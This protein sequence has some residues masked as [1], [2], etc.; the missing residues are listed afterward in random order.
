MITRHEANTYYPQ[1]LFR[2][3]DISKEVNVAAS[4]DYFD[5]P[6]EAY[7]ARK[8][9]PQYRLG[10]AGEVIAQILESGS[11]EQGWVHRAEALHV[12]SV[13][14]L[15]ELAPKDLVDLLAPAVGRIID[16]RSEY[17]DLH[18]YSGLL[19]RTVSLA[20]SKLDRY[21]VAFDVM[22]R[23]H[24]QLATSRR[25]HSAIYIAEAWQQIYLQECGQL[26]RNVEAALLEQDRELTRLNLFGRLPNR[27]LDRHSELRPLRIVARAAAESGRLATAYI[28]FVKARE[29]LPAA[30]DP[31][32][33][34]LAV[35]SWY[36]TSAIMYM[37]A[38]LLAGLIELCAHADPSRYLLPVPD[39]WASIIESNGH[40]DPALTVANQMDLARNGL[41]WAFLHSGEH[42]YVR[43]T[44]MGIRRGVPDYLRQPVGSKLDTVRCADEIARNK[45]NAGILDNLAHSDTYRLLAER[46]GRGPHGYEAWL[47]HRHG[48][49][50]TV[51]DVNDAKPAELRTVGSPTLRY[52]RATARMVLYSHRYDNVLRDL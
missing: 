6:Y 29:G 46:G 36:V 2:A 10:F 26:S 50:T 49:L 20:A 21:I 37:R 42:P 52:L 17:P 33:R 32:N 1:Q 38:L 43:T 44:S 4:A 51:V 5:L 28:N 34:R 8:L 25:A 27:D 39:L 11:R 14:L 22:N 12:V 35:S 18:R 7:N 15:N 30:V 9:S 45:H 16:H 47:D 48:R 23:A 24:T 3:L 13:P 19:L 41:I 31:E 40:D